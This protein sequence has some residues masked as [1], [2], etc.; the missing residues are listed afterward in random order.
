MRKF[1]IT[2]KQ[3]DEMLD[4][5]LMFSTDP[6]TEFCGSEVGLTEPVGDDNFGEIMT[7]D[8]RAREMEPSKLSRMTTGR[9]GYIGPIVY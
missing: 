3:L 9:S 2:K 7:G 8:D 4:S 5:D 6:T 1:R